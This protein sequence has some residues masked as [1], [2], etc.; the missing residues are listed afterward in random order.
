MYVRLSSF[1]SYIPL[2]SYAATL[3]YKKI[4][5]FKIQRVG[6]CGVCVCS[7][8][9]ELKKKNKKNTGG[10]HSETPRYPPTVSP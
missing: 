10:L 8:D 4:Q 9:L 2:Y 6:V 7:G 1:P 3:H 5:S